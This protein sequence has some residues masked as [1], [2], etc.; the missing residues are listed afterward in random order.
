MW[1]RGRKEMNAE[2]ACKSLWIYLNYLKVYFI[3][4][5][6]QTEVR[7]KVLLRGLN[8]D[9]KLVP[10]FLLEKKTEENKWNLR[11]GLPLF[12]FS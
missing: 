8:F 9:E 12:N 11:F 4:C 10:A 6:F 7:K 3:Y 1:R 5:F 2:R